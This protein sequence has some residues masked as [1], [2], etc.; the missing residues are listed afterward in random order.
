MVSFYLPDRYYRAQL[1]HALR[2]APDLHRA[3]GIVVNLAF[4]VQMWAFAMALEF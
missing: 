1:R 4:T 3:P 2:R